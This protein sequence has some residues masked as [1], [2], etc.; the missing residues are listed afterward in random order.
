[1]L[2]GFAGFAGNIIDSLIGDRWQVKYGISK[3]GPLYDSQE[4]SDYTA[5]KGF[6]WMNNDMVNFLAVG[7][8][9]VLGYC[10]YCY[11]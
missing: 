6:V 3:K 4:E 11:L 2:I 7:A 8:G 10:V 5:V 9:S 1:L